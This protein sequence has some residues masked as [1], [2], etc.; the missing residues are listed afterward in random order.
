MARSL[1]TRT[2]LVCAAVGVATGLLG[3]VAGWVTIAV[4]AAA[5]VVYGFVLGVHVLPGVIAQRL[6]RRPGAALA[7]HVLAALVSSA[8][9]P[10]YLWQFLLTALLFGGVQEASAAIGRYRSW[11][12]L[13]L[14]ATA[15]AIGALVAVAVAFAADL[16]NLALWAQVLYIVLAVAG[17][18]A[19]SIVGLSVSAALRRAGV[20]GTEASRQG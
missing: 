3:A 19:W 13:R 10:M 20:A 12:P 5:P 16:E 14:I 15:V 2:L 6:L 1:D 17:P 4:L 8:F 7:T 11:S 18:V 9:A